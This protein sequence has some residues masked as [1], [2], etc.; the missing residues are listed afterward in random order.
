MAKLL[1]KKARCYIDHQA[2]YLQSFEM[3][4]SQETSTVEGSVYGDDFEL[5]EPVKIK[6]SFSLQ[7]RL[8][9]DYRDPADTVDQLIDKFAF[10]RTIDPV[11]GLVKTTPA[12]LSFINRALPTEGDDALFTRGW[13]NMSLAMPRDG[14]SAVDMKL[15]ETGPIHLGKILRLVEVTLT[16]ASPTDNGPAVNLGDATSNIRAAL[17]VIKYT[18]N[19]GSPTGVTAKIQSDDASGFPSP[20]DRLTFATNTDEGAEWK[21]VTINYGSTTEDWHR[22]VLTGAGPS[23]WSVTIGVLC[24][25]KTN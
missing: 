2:I 20:T 12:V 1:G 5:M 17:H 9:N 15:T 8:V 16:N 25:A 14:L 10:G 18:V 22:L 19:S 11:T 24:I 23:T 7:A 3:E 4:H 21:E 6:G 13:G